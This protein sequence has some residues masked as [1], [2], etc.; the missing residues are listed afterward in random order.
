MTLGVTC[1]LVMISSLNASLLH[2]PGTSICST[3]SLSATQE[4]NSKRGKSISGLN[5]S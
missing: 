3:S 2:S 1:I 5:I 4:K